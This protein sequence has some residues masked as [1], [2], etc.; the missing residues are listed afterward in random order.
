MPI[1][2]ALNAR[3]RL[4]V[5]AALAAGC[6]LAFIAFL[7]LLLEWRIWLLQSGL[8]LIDWESAER[9]F[10]A[11]RWAQEP[12]FTNPLRWLPLYFALHGTFL[13]LLGEPLL[14]HV[15]LNTVLSLGGLCA[16]WGVLNR[17]NPRQDRQNLVLVA[18]G[19]LSVRYVENGL[20]ARSD[21]LF[22]LSVFAGIY[23]HLRR[24]ETESRR[25]QALCLLFLAAA[26]LTRYE[27]WA[28]ALC[29]LALARG[30]PLSRWDLL[31]L[32]PMGLWLACGWHDQRS[33]LVFLPDISSTAHRITKGLNGPNLQLLL[34]A[35]LLGSP[36]RFEK[37]MS[38]VMPL[39]ALAAICGSV[40]LY[41]T[42][43]TGRHYLLLS[44]VPTLG[45][46]YLSV[47]H[48][49][50][51][52][53]E[54]MAVFQLL[55]LAPLA[56]L[57][58]R[59]L[60]SIGMW[61]APLAFVASFSVVLR[62]GFEE[63]LPFYDPGP[64]SRRLGAILLDLSRNSLAP[65]DA[66]LCEA[67]PF[68]PRKENCDEPIVFRALAYPHRMIFGRKNLSYRYRRDGR[69]LVEQPS[70]FD[71]PPRKLQER[72]KME[73]VRLVIVSN[74]ELRGKLGPGWEPAGSWGGQQI[75]LR[76]NDRLLPGLA[77]RLKSLT[78]AYP[79]EAASRR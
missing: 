22:L 72:L 43:R 62:L 16:Y 42:G 46:A 41:R 69:A 53:S 65:T 47:V 73:T 44:W 27:G 36:Y 79:D 58:G 71:L 4:P 24:L 8:P 11:R 77:A 33:P 70:L 74:P 39:M 28:L 61:A 38:V 35:L 7:F 1:W 37:E 78:K 17:I 45:M 59:M 51:V 32:L 9:L 75:I 67:R 76:R 54:H 10:L 40:L 21:A 34:P 31:V 5:P 30:R 48:H 2:R 26:C 13:R 29:V 50:P 19:G 15:A 20:Y 23:F 57:L 63:R 56:P 66:I 18:L 64:P 3:R 60:R 6:G 55:L 14:S 52:A 12:F 49:Y 68:C 25:D